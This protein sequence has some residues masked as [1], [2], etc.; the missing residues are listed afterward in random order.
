MND[1]NNNNNNNDDNN[2]NNNNSSNDI[3]INTDSNYDHDGMTERKTSTSIQKSINESLGYD[4]VIDDDIPE[5]STEIYKNNELL[6]KQI[7]NQQETM[8][9][10][11]PSSSFGKQAVSS[12][13]NN[14]LKNDYIDQ[15]NDDNDS[16]YDTY[17]LI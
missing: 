6:I 4:S 10:I 14:N 5:T 12:D 3:D 1:N 15:S 17:K 8:E 2:N 11:S 16:T 9:N 13:N 7:A